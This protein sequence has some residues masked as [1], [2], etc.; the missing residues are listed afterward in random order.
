M[1]LQWAV[2]MVSQWAVLKARMLA[3]QMVPQWAALKALLLADQMA[4][5]SAVPSVLS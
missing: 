1:A 3:V 4:L 2:L 5:L